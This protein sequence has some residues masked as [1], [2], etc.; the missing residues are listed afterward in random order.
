MTDHGLN[1]KHVQNKLKK[2][3]EI[4]NEYV[5]I[6]TITVLEEITKENINLIERN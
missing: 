5:H 2:N 1:A 3:M 4:S 6:R